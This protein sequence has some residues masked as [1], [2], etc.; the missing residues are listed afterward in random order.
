MKRRLIK[1]GIDRKM[2]TALLLLMMLMT[3]A[4]AV[5]SYF[6]IINI[7]YT[8]YTVKAQDLVRMLANQVDGDWLERFSQDYVKDE[9]YY[10]VKD[11]LDHIKSDF[12]GVQ[13]LY[14]YKPG[15]T[16]MTYLVEGQKEGDDPDQMASPGD[17][18]NYGE[19]DYEYLV[20][21]IRAQK[22]S[23]QVIVGD[24]AGYGIPIMAWAP[25]FNSKG[26]MVAMVEADY[27][28]ENIGP[29]I[30]ATILKIVAVQVV[31][32]FFVVLLMIIVIRGLIARPLNKLTNIVDS[33]K[34]GEKIDSKIDSLVKKMSKFGGD[35]EISSLS[36]SFK[37]M[38]VRIEQYIK[39][40]TAVTAEKERISAELNVATQIQAD[41]LPRIFPPFPDKHEFE[42]YAT[43]DP[44][45]EVGGDFYDFFMIDD[46]HLG[47]VMAD[48][49]GKGVP[50]A[51]FMVIAKTLIKNRSLT[52]DFTSPKDVLADVNNMLCEG[53]EAELFV[54]VWFGVL[55]IST[56][57]IVFASAG[58]EYPAFYRLDQGYV[59]EKDKHGP[60]LATMEGLRF[61]DNETSLKPGETL[62]LYT[63]GVTEA[64]DSSQTLF[65]EDR[66][67]KAL[68]E[69]EKEDTQNLLKGVRVKIDEFV[70]DAPQFDDITM[71]AIRYLG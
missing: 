58:H 25:V 68:S 44:A 16:S 41:M 15:E 32:I 54:T 24:D 2:T 40:I 11:N 14:I 56:G 8:Q 10:E 9:T 5:I 69:F 35:D 51:L 3:V 62:F 36:L 31:C 27:I 26:E 22:A 64:T 52:G 34:Q 47:L 37:E 29:A 60:P 61:R 50:A 39:D 20:P 18:Y 43:M 19:S 57:D 48:V 55:T 28:A 30:N 23:D 53:N 59:L 65:G 66:M 70:G 42:L 17:S 4:I 12:T 13:Y 63:D 21:D 49:S 38:T 7:Y 71:L 33:Y 45:K 1:C 46:D 67:L 6:S